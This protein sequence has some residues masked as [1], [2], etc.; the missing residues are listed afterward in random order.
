MG[1]IARLFARLAAPADR[2]PLPEVQPQGEVLARAL[3]RH[4]GFR[5]LR[6]LDQ[7]G[8][9][10]ALALPQAGEQVGVVVDT[11][12]T[13]LDPLEDRLIEIATQRFL[14]TV[15]G[16]IR[17]IERVRYWLEDPERPLPALIRRLTGLTD[18][19]LRDRLF[20]T[21]AIT[22]V[23]EEAA[24]VIAHNAAFDRPFLD[25]RFPSPRYRAWACSLTQLDWPALG[26]EGRSLAHLVM[27]SG[28]FFVG[29]RASND[30]LAL[31]SLLGTIATDERTILSHL[32]ERCLLD[33][34]RM[35]AV[36]APFDA[37]DVLKAHGYR[38]NSDRR[39]W[40]REVGIMDVAEET[41]WLDQQVYRGRGTPN[42]QRVTPRERFASRADR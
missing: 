41:E 14:F 1:L 26:F 11:E 37:K 29:H 34:F 28:R 24:V 6:A 2:P 39:F 22:T 9:V 4:P 20:D 15:T 18:D 35:D 32:L 7:S 36:G 3:E 42:V 38:W 25:A 31:T 21:V 27:Q 33:S 30:V 10:D 8:N 23:L 13:G 17:Q 40:S 12:T 16:E 19:D 5:V